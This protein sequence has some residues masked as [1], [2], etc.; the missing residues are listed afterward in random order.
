MNSRYRE[1]LQEGERAGA[2]Y[3]MASRRSAPV[4]LAGAHL[5]RREGN[6]IEFMDHRE[7]QPGDDLRR[8]DWSVFARSD[9]LTVKQ[10]REEVTP[11]ADIVIDGS[12]SMSLPGTE[13]ARATLGLAALFA[14]AAANAGFVFRTWIT[15]DGCRAVP[16]GCSS[17]SVW[18][19]IEFD[20]PGSP[21]DSFR[22][23]PPPWRGGGLRVFL[24]D[25][26]WIGKPEAVL[27]MLSRQAAS[28]VIVQILAQEDAEPPER[29][30]LRLVDSENEEVRDLF[31]DAL[32]IQRYRNALAGHQESW[33]RAARQAG[34]FMITVLAERLV[35]DWRLDDLVA[36]EILKGHPVR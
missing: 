35:A 11:Q 33:H 19:D 4:G 31:V 3:V 24:S 29:G 13:K 1:Y 32:S 14:T 18:E 17:P 23:S 28:T 16:N 26:L 21:E 6:S 25:L 27:S 8:I 15:R 30:N 36:A 9:R 2:G 34:A 7:Y 12:R 10:F 5:G 22:R 20:F